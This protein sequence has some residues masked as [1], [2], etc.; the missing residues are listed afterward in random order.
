MLHEDD[1][2][3]RSRL[4]RF[5]S[6]SLGRAVAADDA[7]LRAHADRAARRTAAKRHLAA[8]FT[9]VLHAY[10][11]EAL[12]L[13]TPGAPEGGGPP[14]SQAPHPR[15]SSTPTTAALIMELVPSFDEHQLAR[16]ADRLRPMQ[17]ERIA[18]LVRRAQDELDAQLGVEPGAAA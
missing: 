9:Q 12:G 1:L 6:R 17:H 4:L 18:Q 13:P 3:L 5:A 10:A 11:T 15:S 2:P 14:P 8:L 7:R 16:L